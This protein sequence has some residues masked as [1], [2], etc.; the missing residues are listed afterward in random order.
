M[1]ANR[2]LLPATL[3]LASDKKEYHWNIA[4]ESWAILAV[5][6][7]K[8]WKINPL[9]WCS[10]FFSIHFKY[11]RFPVR[12]KSCSQLLCKSFEFLFDGKYACKNFSVLHWTFRACLCLKCRG[13]MARKRKYIQY[14]RKVLHM[15]VWQALHLVLEMSH[16]FERPHNFLYSV[17]VLWYSLFRTMSLT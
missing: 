9:K 12:K 15:A 2:P 16:Q 5:G 4:W 6:T 17:S 3:Q 11:T 13:W 7:S 10:F 14:A 8:K 1:Q